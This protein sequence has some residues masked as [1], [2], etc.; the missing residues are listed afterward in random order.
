MRMV[1]W[2]TYART[3]ETHRQRAHACPMVHVA[4][5]RHGSRPDDEITII[6]HD[7]LECVA[8]LPDVY[9]DTA[10]TRLRNALRALV[11]PDMRLTGRSRACSETLSSVRTIT[12]RCTCLFIVV[13]VIRVHLY[14]NAHLRSLLLS[15][16][17]I[18]VGRTYF[19]HRTVPRN[20]SLI[21]KHITSRHAVSTRES[22]IW[23]VVRMCAHHIIHIF[24]Y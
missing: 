15:R 23:V 11:W 20:R 12:T 2:C 24:T 6:S 13:L 16:S 8:G 4:E 5:Y 14:C 9:P 17:V 21:A 3:R 7:D 22:N 1:V 18:L 19:F 10:D